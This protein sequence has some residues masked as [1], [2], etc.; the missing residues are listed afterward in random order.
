MSR[1]EQ[2]AHWADLSAARAEAATAEAR[3][4]TAEKLA[5]EARARAD[6]AEATAVGLRKELETGKDDFK[7]ARTHRALVESLMLELAEAKQAADT[8]RAEA[9]AGEAHLTQV[10]AQKLT[11]LRAQAA[12]ATARANAAEDSLAE[13]NTHLRILASSPTR[14]AVHLVQQGLED[15]RS[16]PA[17]AKRR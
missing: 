16:P 5:E 8:A 9:A 7:S 4:A 3:A 12:E 15:A 2:S 10:W 6:A 13:A 11:A 14:A 1:S 17:S